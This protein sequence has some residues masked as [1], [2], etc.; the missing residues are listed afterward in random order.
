MEHVVDHLENEE[1]PEQQDNNLFGRSHVDEDYREEH[2]NNKYERCEDGSVEN[3]QN[4]RL[5]SYDEEVED[6][7]THSF[8]Q[9]HVDA[10]DPT[11]FIEDFDE[12][13]GE[14]GPMEHTQEEEGDWPD[15]EEDSWDDFLENEEEAEQQD[16]NS[17][18]QTD[19]NAADLNENIDD[20]H[21]VNISYKEDIPAK[22][23]ANRQSEQTT[24][25]INED[26]NRF[27]S[28]EQ[29]IPSTENEYIEPVSNESFQ[30]ESWDEEEHSEDDAD[31]GV[32]EIHDDNT[33]VKERFQPENDHFN[34]LDSNPTLVNC[35]QPENFN[36]IEGSRTLTGD[37]IQDDSNEKNIQIQIDPNV[38]AGLTPST[39]SSNNSVQENS[40][41]GSFSSFNQCVNSDQRSDITECIIPINQSSFF[42]AGQDCVSNVPINQSSFFSLGHDYVPHGLR[43]IN[44][45]HISSAAQDYVPH[46]CDNTIPI[47]G[48]RRN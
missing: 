21:Y 46:G 23:N 17:I 38:H 3:T 5:D 2:I 7:G 34:S 11:E 31:S 12:E 29:V 47:T 32:G 33:S 24:A 15:E 26:E 48:T 4:G 36:S 9:S 40:I 8:G 14:D 13:V 27:E 35:E 22:S 37:H 30:D 18:A 42:S 1:E 45:S 19:V 16:D 25:H 39:P 20:T 44:P 6:Q 41:Q 43:V 28:L 10:S